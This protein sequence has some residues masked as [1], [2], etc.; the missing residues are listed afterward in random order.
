MTT[1]SGQE[2]VQQLGCIWDQVLVVL[3]DG[4]H[5]KDSILPHKRVPVFQAGPDSRYQ[6]L[7]ELRLSDLLQEPQGRSS[8]VLVGMLLRVASVGVLN[9]IMSLTRSFR[10]ALL[11]GQPGLRKVPHQTRIISC[12]S[13]P[14]SSSFG[15]TLKP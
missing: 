11:E 2:C 8:N 3:E 5:G 1:Y 15:H 9:G 13:L 6:G 4:V 10:R 12:L 7:K 14:F